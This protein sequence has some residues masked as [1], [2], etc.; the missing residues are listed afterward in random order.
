MRTGPSQTALGPGELLKSISVPP[1]AEG[2]GVAYLRLSARSRVDL[3]A[4]SVAAGV[5]MEGGACVEARIALGAV[6]PTPLLAFAAA[7][8]LEGQKLSSDLLEEVG[9]KAAEEAKPVT[10]V[11]ATAPYRRE[12]VYVLTKR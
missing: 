11:R 10:D 3:S 4:V 6:G 2:T 9:R 12:M 7:G 8:M 1:P 5:R